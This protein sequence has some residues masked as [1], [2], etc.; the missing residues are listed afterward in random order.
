MWKYEGPTYW[1]WGPMFLS[2]AA[3][4]TKA[5]I[6]VELLAVLA[7]LATF[8]HGGLFPDS[9]SGNDSLLRDQRF[10]IAICAFLAATVSHSLWSALV[11]R[12]V[13]ETGA[14]T[15]HVPSVVFIRSLT[16]HGIAGFDAYAREVWRL[17]GH[18]PNNRDLSWDGRLKVVSSW[19]FIMQLGVVA[20][21]LATTFYLWVAKA[22]RLMGEANEEYIAE[23]PLKRPEQ[24][25]LSTAPW[26]LRYGP[27]AL[28]AR[29]LA[30]RGFVEIGAFEAVSPHLTIPGRYFYCPR[31]KVHSMLI[32]S[33]G[34]AKR[35]V[36]V[37]VWPRR[38]LAHLGR[39][40]ERES[41]AGGM[42]R[43]HGHSGSVEERLDAHVA[44]L[45][46]LRKKHGMASNENGT[47]AERMTMDRDFNVRYYHG[48]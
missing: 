23:E 34:L 12:T 22:R 14:T 5:L 42:L 11:F 21:I 37:A 4:L 7:L 19:L 35:L 16:W 25:V 31:R 17:L 36:H 20:V 44:W 18:Q 40:P 3:V 8:D 2:L 29:R 10:D 48:R 13:R 39:L 26:F 6:A 27:F 32:L 30:R 33:F 24:R 1:R 46:Q 15:K 47:L 9:W 41:Y 45:E 38:Y 28:S 43:R